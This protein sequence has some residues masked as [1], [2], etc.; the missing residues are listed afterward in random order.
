MRTEQENRKKLTRL[1]AVGKLVEQLT[2][3]PKVVGL[4]PTETKKKN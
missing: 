3:D 4:N 1:E 2:S